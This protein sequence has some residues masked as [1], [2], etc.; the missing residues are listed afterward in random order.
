MIKQVIMYT[1]VC[2]I[3]G[4]DNGKDSDIA[5]WSD[6]EGARFDAEECGFEIIDGKDVCHNCWD[7]DDDDKLIIKKGGQ[8]E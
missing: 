1:V 8:D 2:D 4:E 7:F 6:E 3:C 5:A